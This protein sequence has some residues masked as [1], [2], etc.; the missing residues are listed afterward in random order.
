ME[1][2]EISVLMPIYNDEKTLNDC[3]ESILAQTFRNFELVVLDDGSTDSSK[4]ILENFALKEKRIKLFRNPHQGIVESL[5]AGLKHCRGRYIARMDGDDLM[6]R[7]RLEKQLFFLNQHPETALVGSLVQGIPEMTNYQKWSNSLISDKA[8][9]DEIFVESPIMHPTFFA[10]RALFE[11]LKGYRQNPWAEDY[12]F[13]LRAY[14]HQA[15][16][17]KV[18]EFLVQKKDS[19]TRLSRI[20]WK[21]KRPAMFHAKLHYFLKCGFLEN[22][23]GVIIAGTGPSGRKIA[24]LCKELEIPVLGFIDN[25]PGP[26]QRTVMDIPA[27]GI[28]DEIPE[29]VLEIFQDSIVLL[30]IGS[31]KGRQQWIDLLQFHAVQIDYIRFL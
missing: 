9:K 20:D 22:K 1:N 10:R 3:I 23:K 4:T 18:P 27:W 29:E 24:S 30:A 16:F 15:G 5:N 17:G 19:P 31:K 13:L 21:Y 6:H 26:P 8:I 7:Q 12:D 2:P 14:Q 28:E 25:R 11:V